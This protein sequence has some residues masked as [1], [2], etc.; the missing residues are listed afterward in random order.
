LEKTWFDLLSKNSGNLFIP[1][2]AVYKKPGTT[3]FKKTTVCVIEKADG[4]LGL[5]SAKI[6]DDEAAAEVTGHL[7]RFSRAFYEAFRIRRNRVRFWRLLL[8]LLEKENAAQEGKIEDA[9]SLDE[10]QGVL[11]WSRPPDNLDQWRRQLIT[12][13]AD[14]RGPFLIK[15]GTRPQPR[16]TT[17][18]VHRA[19]GRPPQIGI[20]KLSPHFEEAAKE[21]VR[22]TVKIVLGVAVPH[23]KL[24][25]VLEA[26]GSALFR[27]AMSVIGQYYFAPYKMLMDD[28]AAAVGPPAAAETFKDHAPYWTITLV[29]WK[30][31]NESPKSPFD[32]HEFLTEVRHALRS[33]DENEV[34]DCF[35]YLGKVKILVPD[36]NSNEGR[37]VLNEQCVPALKKYTAAINAARD[38][39]KNLFTS[40]LE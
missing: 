34:K 14:S 32:F 21:Y 23:L 13:F 3:I 11:G 31:Y 15:I 39:L 38:Q 8:L 19:R 17:A 35:S 25:R 9:F 2:E 7:L 20:F 28:L 6:G 24:D 18:V 4:G 36:A 40:E 27:K 30:Q 16:D 10:V 26:R 1:I 22:G 12:Q 37:F 33:V 29:A 5:S